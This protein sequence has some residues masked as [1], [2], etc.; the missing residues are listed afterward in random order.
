MSG[1]ENS[2]SH[3]PYCGFGMSTVESDPSLT[4]D[5]AR[6]EC[7]THGW[8]GITVSAEDGVIDVRSQDTESDRS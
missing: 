2:V 8:V 4:K 5:V 1:I 7:P 6:G 3:C